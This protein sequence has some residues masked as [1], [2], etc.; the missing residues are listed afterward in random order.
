MAKK[1]RIRS[2]IID[3]A[4]WGKNLLLDSSTKQMC[5]LGHLGLAC[6]LSALD[7]I[8]RSY[9]C[10]TEYEGLYPSAFNEKHP[11]KAVQLA[12]DINDDG[13][14]YKPEKERRLIT[15]FGAY[16]IKLKFIGDRKLAGV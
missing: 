16:G 15:L 3:R 6:G 2:L 7:M 11:S 4:K 8:G 13:K 5:C 14:M 10:T 1:K 12:A 9:P